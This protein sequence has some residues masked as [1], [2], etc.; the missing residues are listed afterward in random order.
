MQ[1]QMSRRARSARGHST[2]VVLSTTYPLQNWQNRGRDKAAESPHAGCILCPA[3]AMELPIYRTTDPYLA[4]FLSHRDA[5]LAGCKRLRP[6]KNEFQFVA[7]ARLHNLLRLYW[8]GTP[9]VV[10]PSQLLKRQQFLKRLA[11]S[12]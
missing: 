7:D 10:V 3:P 6:K 1:E 4:S 2:T 9:T 5:V 12:L 11:L 8:S